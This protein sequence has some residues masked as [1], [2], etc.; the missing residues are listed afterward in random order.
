MAIVLFTT[1]TKMLGIY[2][3]VI[4]MTFN[5]SYYSIYLDSEYAD[6]VYIHYLLKISGNSTC[7]L[8]RI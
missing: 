3:P 5:L 1:L 6:P 4:V 7:V 2:I 8:Q